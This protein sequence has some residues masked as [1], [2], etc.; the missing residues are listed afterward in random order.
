MERA[1]LD[2]TGP[3][4]SCPFAFDE[5]AEVP[6]TSIGDLSVSDIWIPA[7]FATP[8]RCTPSVGQERFHQEV[9]STLQYS[10][11]SS[12]APSSVRTYE[13]T[14]RA[15]APKVAAK[16]IS[17]AIPTDSECAF[18]AFLDAVVIRGPKFPLSVTGQSAA[19]WSYVTLVKA[20]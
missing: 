1:D 18:Y 6:S 7:S 2:L 4:R 15:T 14:L 12:A 17:R 8:V 11:A 3:D 20:A 5:D 13:A 10:F 19:R 9:R 16:L